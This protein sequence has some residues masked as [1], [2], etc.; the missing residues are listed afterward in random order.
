[1]ARTTNSDMPSSYPATRQLPERARVVA[2]VGTLSQANHRLPSTSAPGRTATVTSAAPPLKL[3]R[4]PVVRERTGLSR[5]TIWRL[6]RRGDFPRHY[7]I[8]PNVVAWVDEEISEWIR[9]KAVHTTAQTRTGSPLG[10]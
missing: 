4:F 7:R 10:G 3:I 2:R 5:S 6:E 9:T 1:M 8:A